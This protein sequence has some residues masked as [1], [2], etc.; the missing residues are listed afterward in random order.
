MKYKTLRLNR[1]NSQ[2]RTILLIL[3]W[4]FLY[5]ILNG[6][7]LT[8][9]DLKQDSLKSRFSEIHFSSPGNDFGWG[10]FWLATKSLDKPINISFGGVGEHKKC[11]KQLRWI[12]YNSARW[13]RLW[14]IDIDTLSLLSWSG[15]GYGNLSM[16]GGFYTACEWEAN[17]YDIFGYISYNWAG[18]TGSLIAGAKLNYTNN[19]YITSF[20]NNFQYFNNTTPLGYF[21]DSVGGIWF[22]GGALTGDANLINYLNT[23]GSINDSFTITNNNISTTTGNRTI[24][25]SSW[26]AQDTMW[27]ILIQGN[28][29][30][31]KAIDIYERKAFLGNLEKRTILI[32]GADLNSATVMNSAKKNAEILCRGKS[33]F[34]SPTSTT[35]PSNTST[36][37]VLCYKN[38]NLTI[39]LANDWS[40]Y[41]NKTIIMK[42][43]NIILA[44]SMKNI[45]PSLDVFI[46]WGNLYIDSSSFNYENFDNQGFPTIP[47]N[48]ITSGLLLKGNFVINGLLIGGTPGSESVI[49]HKLHLQ[50]RI[51]TLNT[52]T[53]PAD[54]RKQQILN[55]F[56]VDYTSWISLENVFTWQCGLDGIANDG[57]SCT[58]DNAVS[59]TPFVV[60]DGKYSSNI[61]K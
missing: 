16:T 1:L 23:T 49:P 58:G 22:I 46:D 28:V 15:I 13:A 54:G 27:N 12:Y 55:L 10:I 4:I 43:W 52:P 35:L 14:P 41:N 60:L 33:Y 20:T 56:P 34:I 29:V 39:D 50:G 59:L 37:N 40:Y 51:A 21:W 8:F 61:L 24:T 31:S 53:N 7:T 48:A 5:N 2:S 19:S 45:S 42:N 3:L 6:L 11:Y 9:T 32:N 38:V 57:S 36:D 25:T 18:T 30:L 26:N 17:K 44:R 47:T